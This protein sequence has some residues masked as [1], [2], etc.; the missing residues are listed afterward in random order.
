M[1]IM[2][3]FGFK[4]ITPSN[5][6]ESDNVLR[7]FVKLS[8]CRRPQTVTGDDYLKLI[9]APKLFKSVPVDVQSLFEVARGAMVY[10]YFFYPLYTLATEQLFRVA[11]AA[12]TQKCKALGAKNLKDSF[13]NK[14]DWL[15]QEGVVSDSEMYRWNVTR[16]LRNSASH[17]NG[18]SILTPGDTIDLL[19]GIAEQINSLFDTSNT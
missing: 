4:E 11:E 18:Q 12:V 6:L 8:S 19:G 16:E 3:N 9:L 7:G 15:I 2:T 14:I 17:P 5:W 1:Y 10:G 13:K